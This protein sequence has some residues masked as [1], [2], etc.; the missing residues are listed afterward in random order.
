MAYLAGKNGSVTIGADVVGQVKSWN[1][2]I[3]NETIEVRSFDQDYVEAIDGM[4]GL[5]G[6]IS[7]YI[8]LDSTGAVQLQTAA[9][10]HT[11]ISDLYFYIDATNYYA[12]NLV[13]DANAG[14]FIET[15]NIST[16]TA[17]VVE[18]DMSVK[19]SGAWER[20]TA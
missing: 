9:D 3:G 12:P 5:T 14:V 16:D 7:G 1:L 8:D 13:A 17:G 18:F 11:L 10:A 15:Y 19:F 6:T 4:Q 20:T 2:T